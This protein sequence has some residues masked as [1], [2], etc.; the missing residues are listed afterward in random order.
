MTDQTAPTYIFL[1][2][3]GVL[4]RNSSPANVFDDSCLHSL[5]LAVGPIDDP[6]IVVSSTWRLG[7]SL[8]ALKAR[9]PMPLAERIAGVTPEVAGAPVYQRFAE[10]HAYCTKKGVATDEWIA[11]DDS[12][13]LYP[14]DTRLVL[15]NP[16][17]GF[18]QAAI[19]A[20]WDLLGIA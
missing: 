3:D 16:A 19:V 6:R 5:I 13:E 9:F 2:I 10:I 11:I 18:D 8:A 14:P 15:T 17:V 1:D 7:M 12:A 20:M 4:R